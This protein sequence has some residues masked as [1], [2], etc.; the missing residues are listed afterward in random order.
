[1][2]KPALPPPISLPL[3]DYLDFFVAKQATLIETWRFSFSLAIVFAS[4]FA[5]S[6]L[7]VFT[8]ASPPLLWQLASVVEIAIGA[9]FYLNAYFYAWSAFQC[10]MM[11]WEILT[12][13]VRSPERVLARWIER[14]AEAE[15]NAPI[16]ARISK[17][18]YETFA[19]PKEM[20]EP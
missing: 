8:G 6:L 15:K 12:G 9:W 1:M 2:A 18:G 10:E 17:L 19:V 3:K 16:M 20:K 4:V 5:T 14:I 13:R 11:C 7:A